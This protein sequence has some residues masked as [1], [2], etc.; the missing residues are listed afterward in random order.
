MGKRI[1]VLGS[2]FAGMAAALELKQQLG[3]EHRVVVISKSD[4]FLFMPSLIWLPFG[5]R[6]AE[7]ITFPLVPIYAQKGIEF[8]AAP[9]TKID[10]AERTVVTER[11][12][13]AYDYLVIATGPKL[14]YAAVPGLGPRDGFTHSIYSLE[15]AERA[16]AA[17]KRFLDEPGPVVVGAVQGASFFGASYEFLFN[18]ARQL[19]KHGL[20]GKVPLTFVTP[21][22]HVAHLGVGGYGEAADVVDRFMRRLDVTVVTNAEVREI[23]PDVIHL[24]RG[25]SFPF[26]YAMLTPPFVGVDAVRDCAEI[27]DPDG[28]VR[29]NEHY[30]TDAHPEVFAAGVA[31]SVE[32]T[33]RTPVPCGVPKTGYMSDQMARAA[34][35][36]VAAAVRGEEMVAMP[37]SAIDAKYVLDAGSTG[38]IMTSDSYLEPREH[39]R[40]IPGPEAHWAKIAFEKYFLA[41]RRRGHV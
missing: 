35:H 2:N 11:S 9:V 38:V 22:P 14:D 3:S 33:E 7:E 29:V 30:Q 27:V 15:D 41:T 25:L 12:R 6:T 17:W 18:L 23:L 13:H 36:N 21:E 1:V 37:P 28:F 5:L 26:S 39:A 16:G 31:V 20:E 8:H 10:L 34:A 32:Q 24:A 19:R 40:L 4:R